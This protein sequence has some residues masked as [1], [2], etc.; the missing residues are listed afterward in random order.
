MYS[1]SGPFEEYIA[2]LSGSTNR[3]CQEQFASTCS[4]KEEN[5]CSLAEPKPL[6]MSFSSLLN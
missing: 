4:I 5:H 6:I 3:R 1:K 2:R